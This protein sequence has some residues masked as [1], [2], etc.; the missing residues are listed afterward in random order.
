M[1]LTVKPPD[2]CWH[3]RESPLHEE[4]HEQ[5][6]DHVRGAYLDGRIVVVLAVSLLASATILGTLWVVSAVS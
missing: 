6:E 4:A 1:T 3:E 5:D 2:T